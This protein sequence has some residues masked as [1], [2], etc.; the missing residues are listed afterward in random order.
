MAL[1]D[2]DNLI[3]SRSGTNFKMPAVQLK[4]YA[5]AKV[6]ISATAPVSP[7]EGGLWWDST[8]DK[9]YIREGGQWVLASSPG[10]G[11]VG[12]GTDSIFFENDQTVTTDYTVTT[13]K[14]A[15]SAGPVTINS[16]VVVTIPSGS[17]WVIV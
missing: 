12:G 17:S 8:N 15:L 16:G 7:V 2:T 6:E 4:D 3:V 14:N 1:Q 11:A 13:D 10:A 5:G 9:L